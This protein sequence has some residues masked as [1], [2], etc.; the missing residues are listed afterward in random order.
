M[1]CTRQEYKPLPSNKK[2]LSSLL[3][4]ASL[5]VIILAMSFRSSDIPPQPYW[6]ASSLE[7][8]ALSGSQFQVPFFS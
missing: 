8:V 3:Y 4:R 1:S 2:T 7:L 6:T 5:L